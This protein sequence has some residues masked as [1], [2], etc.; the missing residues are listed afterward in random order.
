MKRATLRRWKLIISFKG[1]RVF[2]SEEE[3]GMCVREKYSLTQSWSNYDLIC[4]DFSSILKETSGSHYGLLC[5]D[6]LVPVRSSLLLGVT[7]FDI[8]RCGS[9]IPGIQGDYRLRTMKIFQCLLEC[10]EQV[11]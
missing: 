1:T 5:R 4:H 9:A 2:G 7:D 10:L 11:L 3:L 8:C 6:S